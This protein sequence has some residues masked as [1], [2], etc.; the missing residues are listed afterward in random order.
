MQ[1]MTRG[2]LDEGKVSCGVERERGKK[3]LYEGRKKE[4]LW[5]VPGD[6]SRRSV[7]LVSHPHLLLRVTWSS[8]ALREQWISSHLFGRRANDKAKVRSW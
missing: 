8:R 6:L 7:Q 3:I 1:N 2:E 4:R 5:R